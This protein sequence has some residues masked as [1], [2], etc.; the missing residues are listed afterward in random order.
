M[1]IEIDASLRCLLLNDSVPTGIPPAATPRNPGIPLAISA[2]TYASN[3]RSL[4]PG[5]CDA[6][7][8]DLAAGDGFVSAQFGAQFFQ[9]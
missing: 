4:R 1:K 2:F 6:Q 7:E 5:P 8:A 3:W 9:L